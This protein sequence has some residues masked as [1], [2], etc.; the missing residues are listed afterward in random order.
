M[1]LR[2]ILCSRFYAVISIE[3]VSC[4]LSRLLG[5]KYQQ[6]VFLGLGLRKGELQE[7]LTGT[8]LLQAVG[9]IYLS[10]FFPF[11]MFTKQ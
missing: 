5:E 8:F 3:L 2:N 4:T 10:F 9:S 7:N 1:F 6:Y 11:P